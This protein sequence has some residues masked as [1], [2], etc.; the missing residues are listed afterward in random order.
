MFFIKKDTEKNT[1]ANNYFALLL[2]QVI[3][4]ALPIIIYPY[5]V[6]TIKIEKY[7]LIM[8]G[9]SLAVFF[10]LIVDFGFNTSGTRQVA[11]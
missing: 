6:R 5:L 1:V 2:I 3:N 7:G 11:V 10:T 8:I 4:F 9:Q